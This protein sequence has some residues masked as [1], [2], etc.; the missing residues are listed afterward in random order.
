VE[1]LVVEAKK[2]GL[3]LEEVT[4][5]VARH[6]GRLEGMAPLGAGRRKE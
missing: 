1:Q 5:A 6:W 4:D 3:D 2:L